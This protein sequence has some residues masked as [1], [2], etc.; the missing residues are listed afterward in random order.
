QRTTTAWV[1]LALMRHGAIDF[2]IQSALRFVDD[3]DPAESTEWLA[4][5]LLLEAERIHAPG[6]TVE[7]N[8]SA[9]SRRVK[10]LTDHQ[11]QDGGWGWRVGQP[12]DALATGMA[13]YALAQTHPAQQPTINQ[14]IAYLDSTQQPSGS[15]QVPGTKRSAKGKP[16]ATSNY[17]GTAWATVGLLSH[18]QSD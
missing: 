18:D 5:R 6:A 2:D 4:V 16:T 15:W 3:G 1:T 17:W 9:M 10:D 7:P 14:A 13:L 11:N 8:T 12:S